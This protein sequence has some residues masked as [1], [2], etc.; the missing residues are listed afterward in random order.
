MTKTIKGVRY[1]PV[2]ST[3]KFKTGD[4]IYDIENGRLLRIGTIVE[5]YET[6]K[7]YINWTSCTTGVISEETLTILAPVS[8][9]CYKRSNKKII[10]L[11]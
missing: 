1:S 6:D 4:K 10:I 9:W 8:S 3:D 5:E 11:T 2:L 7:Y